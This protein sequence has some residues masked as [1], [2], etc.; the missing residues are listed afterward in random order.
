MFRVI[1][2]L[3]RSSVKLSASSTFV[4]HAKEITCLDI[5]ANDRL[6]V[7]GSMDK[8]AKLWHIDSKTMQLGIAGTL[9][10]HRRGVWDVRF[11]D[12]SEVS[13]ISGYCQKSKLL[14]CF[15]VSNFYF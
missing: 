9:P 7:T 6:C 15:C 2:S 4:A 14:N 1:Y 10:G 13:Y 3:F 5:S 11:C 8:T 12:F